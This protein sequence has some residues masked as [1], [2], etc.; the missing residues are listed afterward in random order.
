MINRKT[1]NLLVE[2]FGDYAHL[3]PYVN[4]I[5]TRDDEGDV[6]TEYEGPLTVMETTLDQTTLEDCREALVA[7]AP[8]RS[9][10]EAALLYLD[11]TDYMVIKCM[12]LGLDIAEEYPEPHAL[13]EVARVIVRLES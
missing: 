13:R 6:I 12:E 9:T 7:F 5:Q 11:R 3:Y 1:N 10:M 2:K 4:E 8:A